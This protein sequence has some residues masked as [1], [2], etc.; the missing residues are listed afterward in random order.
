MFSVKFTV[1]FIISLYNTNMKYWKTY[2]KDIILENL[3]AVVST[4]S[5]ITLWQQIGDHRH[6]FSAL[7]TEV[8][9]QN[10]KIKLLPDQQTDFFA[11]DQP[12]YV[13][14]TSLDIIFKKENYHKYGPV[15]DF[16]LPGEVQ[17][18]EK[19][20]NKRFSYLY[21][22]HKNI[23]Y[24]SESTNP[25]NGQPVFSGSSV[26]IDI[27]TQGAGMVV[28]SEIVNNFVIGQSLLLDN[29]TDQKLPTPFKIKVVYIQP[30]NLAEK[31][32]FKVGL[33]FDDQLNNISYKSIS[34][35]IEIKQRKSQGLDPSKYCGVD[36]N[37]Q[38]R[39]LNKIEAGNKAL[40]NNLKDNIEYLDQ[41]RYM[42]TQMK[43]EFLK[44][45][46]HDL[47]A[48]ALRLSSKELVYELFSELTKNMQEEFLDKL[49]NERPASAICKAQDEI[50]KLVRAKEKSGEI[51]LDP[52][53]F[54]TYV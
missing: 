23:T 17:L 5:E 43:V 11:E 39:L 50:V 15:I 22:D 53:A 28:G 13:H 30:Y 49:Q 31:G 16:G 7:F 2:R 33:I 40:A 29:L 26:L 24:H 54:V 41:L 48:V 32:L 4:K 1:F 21:Q 38:T 3:E 14:I 27:S 9:R 47:L 51:V 35:I 45:V 46:N 8:T 37:D 12:L 42:T 25:T 52:K 6:T 18:F 44:D 20:Q 34:S 36:N 19:R 10:C